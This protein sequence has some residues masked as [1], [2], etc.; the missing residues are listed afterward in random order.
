MTSVYRPN[1]IEKKV[2]VGQPLT[3][4]DELAVHFSVESKIEML[5][6]QA[7]MRAQQQALLETQRLIEQAKQEAANLIESAQ[8]Q[9]QH[10]IETQTQP[11]LEQARQEGFEAGMM[12]AAELVQQQLAD[13]D[14]V[15][16]KAF[17]S[18]ALLLRQAKPQMIQLMQLIL[19]TLIGQ[20]FE[21]QPEAWAEIIETSL[22]KLMVEGHVKIRLHP[23]VLK[24]FGELSPEILDRV[25]ALAHIQFIPHHS[26]GPTDMVV[27]TVEAC[28]DISPLHV[29]ERLLEKT[30]ATITDIQINTIPIEPIASVA[31][32]LPA[33]P[34]PLVTERLDSE[35]R[36]DALDVGSLD[37]GPSDE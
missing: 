20:H 6:N 29:M 17:E 11:V 30:A 2:D 27:E 35:S 28:Y 37:L 31:A 15:M 23:D 1:R 34:E 3:L 4:T 36:P 19:S 21:T 32:E 14:D 8:A 16:G 24:R 18:Q 13:A 5:L 12:R 10:I 26:Y 22:Q 33:P 9:A 25:N 7:Q